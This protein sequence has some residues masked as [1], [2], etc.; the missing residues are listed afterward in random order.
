LSHRPTVCRLIALVL[1]A[2]LGLLAAACGRS[3]EILTPDP[4]DELEASVQSQITEAVREAMGSELRRYEIVASELRAEGRYGRVEA[5]VVLES[6]P[7]FAYDLPYNAENRE[8][9][10]VLY[11]DA[12]SLPNLFKLW[13][14]ARSAALAGATVDVPGVDVQRQISLIPDGMPELLQARLDGLSNPTVDP[15]VGFFICQESSILWDSMDSE[16]A[17]ELQG[18]LPLVRQSMAADMGHALGTE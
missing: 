13:A 6:C 18:L 14:T 7:L 10:W 15:L 3:P 1:L 12:E 4:L 5:R 9:Q 8:G 17:A 2:S 16:L 11:N